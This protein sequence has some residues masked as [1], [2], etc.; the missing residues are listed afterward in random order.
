LLQDFRSG[1]NETGSGGQLTDAAV[2][3]L[4]TAYPNLIH[5]SLDGSKYLIDISLLAFFNNC[6]NL[7]YLVVTGNDKVPGKLKGP[8]LDELREKPDLGRKLEN[9]RLTDQDILDKKL[10]RAIKSLST[11]RKILAIEV[12]NTHERSGHVTTWVGGKEKMGYQ[13]FG[14]SGGFSQFGGW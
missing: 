1:D 11:S 7:R 3:R 5:A 12:G 4:A 2:I 9:I 10:E 6:P 14:G 8:A 13:A